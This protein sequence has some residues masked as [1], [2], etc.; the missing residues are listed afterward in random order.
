M[1]ELDVV[2][3][4]EM[5]HQDGA[6]QAVEVTARDQAIFFRFFRHFD[7][8]SCHS[9]RQSPNNIAPPGPRQG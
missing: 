8:P 4:V 9:R 2:D 6:D 7:L 3:Q 1:H 5:A